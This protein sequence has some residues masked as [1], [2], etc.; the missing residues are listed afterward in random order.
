MQ[1]TLVLATLVTL[2]GCGWNDVRK[3]TPAPATPPAAANAPAA[4]PAPAADPLGLTVQDIDGQPVE[5]ARYR[6]KAVLIVNTASECGFTPQYAGLQQLHERFGPRGLV[7][8]GFPCNDFGGQEPGE[9]S[10]IKTFC[11]KEFHVTFPLM[12]KVHAKG[13]QIA[14]IYRVLTEQTPDGIR[15]PVK[16]NFTKFLIDPSGK[17]V[18]RFEPAVKPDDPRL[19]EEVEK[20]L[21]QQAM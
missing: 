9:A 13:D 2:A 12:Q 20:A 21:P 4:T 11:S 7:V 1:R 5:L 8:L 15:G 17:V 10:E 6:G 18:A 16:W 3:P 19:L 14:P